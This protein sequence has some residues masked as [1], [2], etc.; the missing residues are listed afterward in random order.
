VEVNNEYFGSLSPAVSKDFL[1]RENSFFILTIV[2]F[3]MICSNFCSLDCLICDDLF[4][5]IQTFN[6]A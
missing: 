3:T 5:V 6:K 2:Y 1:N 4:E